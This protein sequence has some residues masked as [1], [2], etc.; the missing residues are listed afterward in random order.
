MHDPAT[1]ALPAG[2]LT[3]LLRSPPQQDVRAARPRGRPAAVALSRG[4]PRRNEIAAFMYRLADSAMVLV[5][6]LAVFVVSNVGM[7]PHGLS[8]F[9]AVRLTIKNVLL[10]VAFTAAW[11]FIAGGCGLYEA[12]GARTWRD[13]TGRVVL[14]C[15][16]GSIAALVFPLTS[17]SAAFRFETILYFWI[18]TTGVALALRSMSHGISTLRSS[19][20]NVLIV[21]SGPRAVELCRM[22]RQD[23]RG[24][25]VLGFVDREVDTVVDAILD[26]RLGSTEDLGAI[27]MSHPV[28]EVLVA[29]PQRSRYA[30]I[31][32]TIE[33]CE[34]AG[35]Q[36]KYLADAFRVSLARPSYDPSEPLPVITMQMVSDGYRLDIK[37]A[38]DLLGA[39]VA[40]VL[41]TPLMLM[42]AAAIKLT[43]RGPVLFAQDRYGRNKHRF[44]MYK[45]RTMV[46]NA[47][48]L[49]PTLEQHNE[50]VGP[51]FKM[52]NDPR[53]TRVG[54]LLRK[55]S[56]DELPQLWNVLRGDMSLVGPRPMSLRDVGLF[57]QPALMRRFSVVPGITGL[58]QVSGRSDL[59]F[60]QWVALDL[61]YIDRWSLWLD[62]TILLRTPWVVLT[63]KGAA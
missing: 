63:A 34:V 51:I 45:F 1:G 22:L 49:L 24:Y 40:L 17:E 23:P 15:T 8:E 33:L 11:R 5:V 47:E 44:R 29:L 3:D 7:M 25:R 46:D 10:I 31:Q 26:K 57:S 62:V 48:A 30:D 39:T 28:D 61:A 53:F 36:V 19:P 50:A 14:A 12:I 21:G 55:W 2:G 58:W 16:L 20:R 32:R 41:A 52:K 13:E 42:T 56:I 18:G 35:V 27:L 4:R 9:L 43:S 54:R 37:R 60:D 38:I 59:T 6:L